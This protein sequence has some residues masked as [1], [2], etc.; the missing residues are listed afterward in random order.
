[1]FTGIIEDRG[2]VADIKKAGGSSKLVLKTALDLSEVKLGDSISVNGVCIT[3][4]KIEGDLLTFDVSFETLNVTNLKD[5]KPNEHVNIERALKAG[6]RFDGHIVSGHI[7]GMGKIT[8]KEKKGDF[9][10][11][12]VNTD[13]AILR[14]IVKKGSIAIDG[15][16]I[17]V[18]NVDDAGFDS[19]MIP[20]TLKMTNL[21]YKNVGATVNLETDILAKYVEKLINT[22]EKRSKSK[23]NAAFLAEHGFI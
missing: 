18:N 4:T 11:I 12:R 6:G 8:R 13:K 22:D 3:V 5:L 23:V 16:S 10:N 9:F 7:D 1:M 15:I 17:T 20:H 2:V 14:Y 19:V 21:E